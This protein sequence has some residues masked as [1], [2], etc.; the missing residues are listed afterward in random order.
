[1]YSVWNVKGSK[2]EQFHKFTEI[3]QCADS[4]IA[5]H[6][7]LEY[8]SR[9]T[10]GSWKPNG[11]LS[12]V[13]LGWLE[14]KSLWNLW[15]VL[16]C[17]TINKMLHN[18]E[19]LMRFYTNPS[20]KESCLGFLVIFWQNTCTI[21]SISWWW[22]PR[23]TVKHCGGLSGSASSMGFSIQFNERENNQMRQLV[24]ARM[25]TARILKS[26]NIYVERRTCFDRKHVGR[27][28]FL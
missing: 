5:Y 22:K 4:E 1:M 14:C 17:D 8:L 7:N 11:S 9:A 15:K 23:K 24:A 18:D 19:F 27:N 6:L 21:S 13:F 2:L 26:E 25:F 20:T 12:S 3:W 10:S 28:C 16:N